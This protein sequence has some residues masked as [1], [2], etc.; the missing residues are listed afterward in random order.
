MKPLK[1]A[2]LRLCPPAY[3]QALV[4]LKNSFWGQYRQTHYSQFGEDVIVAALLREK[5]GF[6][7]DVGANHPRRYS[8]TFLLYRR[9]WRGINIDPNAEAMRSFERSRP[10]DINLTA[11]V[12][13]TKSSLTFYRFSDP[14]YNTFSKEAADSASSKSWLAP[15]PSQEIEV[16]PLAELLR[17]HVPHGTRID[18][19][20]V[21]VEGLDLEVLESN[22]WETFA[23]RVIAVED[24]GFDAAN[25]EHSPIYIYLCGQGYS[26]RAW[27]GPSLIFQRA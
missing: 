4:D 16:Y 26:L 21:D 12:A 14:A 8:N 10:H 5:N 9:G 18:F 17:R 19:L 3:R 6:F 2:L 11:G 13:R 25:P 23:P 27:V 24:H 7:V 22:D 15:L 20:S 1:E